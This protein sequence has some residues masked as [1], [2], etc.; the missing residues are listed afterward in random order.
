ML[1]SLIIVNAP[2]FFSFFWSI[3][4]NLLDAKTQ[5]LIEIYSSPEKGQQRLLQLI[6]ESEL[7]R[8][9]G[10]KA[11]STA[12]IILQE[13]EK[14]ALEWKEIATAIP[15]AHFDIKR[16]Q[17]NLMMGISNAPASTDETKDE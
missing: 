6:D 10:G 2:G 8:D 5:A 13:R 12:E 15:E 17:L 1:H 3:I 16:L 7:P 11:P 4:R 9:Y 14:V